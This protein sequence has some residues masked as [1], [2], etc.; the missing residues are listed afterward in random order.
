ML[1]EMRPNALEGDTIFRFYFPFIQ[2]IRL[3][4]YASKSISIS[5]GGQLNIW[6]IELFPLK[7]N[8]HLKCTATR[9]AC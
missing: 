1:L 7:Q 8:T 4:A 5:I 2:S 6:R 3:H 9:R